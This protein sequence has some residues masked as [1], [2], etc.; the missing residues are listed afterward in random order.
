MPQ[1]GNS[2][3]DIAGNP[4]AATE[5]SG[6]VLLNDYCT[7]V[8]NAGNDVTICIGESV[9]IGAYNTGSGGSGYYNYR[10]R[11][12]ANGTT[13]ISTLSNPAVSPT[14]TTIYQVTVIDSDG[15]KNA[16]PVTVT[17]N[18]LPTVTFS[19][20]SIV[21]RNDAT[22]FRLDN[23]GQLSPAHTTGLGGVVSGNGITYN[24][25]LNRYYFDP[26]QADD[27]DNTITYTYKDGNGCEAAN[28][29]VLRVVSPSGA[30]LNLLSQYC[31]EFNGGI[32]NGLAADLP[33]AVSPGRTY[34]S[35]RL[36]KNGAGYIT[37]P[38][39]DSNADDI[40][41][42]DLAALGPGKFS[43]AVFST[44]DLDPAAGAHLDN[45]STSLVFSKG[46]EPVISSLASGYCSNESPVTLTGSVP[47]YT[48][49]AFSAP[50][51]VA[52]NQFDP[53]AVSFAVGQFQKTITITY[54]YDDDNGCPGFIT[55]DV[56]VYRVP[57]APATPALVEY[58]TEDVVNS[59]TVTGEGGAI[60][61]W[62]KDADTS[63]PA[64]FLDNGSTLD[65]VNG[66]GMPVDNSV[67]GTYQ[68]WV[69]QTLNGC[70]S[71]AAQ[72]TLEIY[73][74]SA[75][76]IMGLNPMYCEDAGPVT[77]SVGDANG[78]PAGTETL[79]INGVNQAAPEF[80]PSTLGIGKHLVT[81]IFTTTQGCADS[82]QMEV[83]VNP[84]QAVNF[85]GFNASR[86]YCYSSD[87][88]TLVGSPAVTTGT[89]GT[90]SSSTGGLV[91]NDGSGT[92][93]FSP[94]LAAIAAGADSLS[95]TTTHDI[96][97]TFTDANGC[98]NYQ[99]YTFTVNPLPAANYSGFNAGN[100]YCYDAGGVAL[101]G[102]P[103]TSSGVFSGNGIINNGDGTATFIP[104]I[105][106]TLAGST[107]P[108]GPVTTHNITYTFTDANSCK[109]KVTK[110]VTVNPLPAV[111]FSGYNVIKKY[112]YD[113]GAVLLTGSPKNSAGIFSGSGIANNGN[114]T[115]T[116]TP[117]LAAAD[118]G[119]VN[120]TDFTTDHKLI[121]TYTNAQG[122]VN[123]ASQIIRVNA[124]PA[125]TI[126]NL[127]EAYC[128]DQPAFTLK[129]HPAGGTLSGPGISGSTFNPAAAGAGV[130]TI[131]Y[132]YTNSY[133]ACDNT[134]TR[135]VTIRPLP[136]ADFSFVASCNNATVSFSDAS[137]I[138]KLDTLD[139]IEK[140]SWKFGDFTN[141]DNEQNPVHTYDKS[142][143]YTITLTPVTAFGCRSSKETTLSIDA[144][145]E[146]DFIWKNACLGDTTQFISTSTISL[147]NITSYKW[148]FGDGFVM[149][150]GVQEPHIYDQTGAYQASL[151]LTTKY[152]CTDSISKQIY[153]LPK[154]TTFPY[155]ED[156]E[157]TNHGWI[158]EGTNASWEQGK[159]AAVTI[160]V[161]A[162]G[163]QVFMTNLDE[164]YNPNE[165]SWVNSPC[166][167]ISALENPVLSFKTWY[168]TDIDF[169]GAVIQTSVDDGQTWQVLGSLEEGI[170]WYNSAAIVGRPGQQETTSLGMDGYQHGLA[171]CKIFV[172]PV[173][174][175]KLCTLPHSLWQQC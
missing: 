69:T 4:A 39:T 22:P 95:P 154:V 36:Y 45:F 79:K 90:F 35:L 6:A 140:Y 145:P 93:T 147:G 65:P 109:N 59:L 150:G 163:E 57:D 70:E 66:S 146:A 77:F 25:A 41:D 7:V 138:T 46:A 44:F 153:I 11:I 24:S 148:D 78:L 31:F 129:V 172:R 151:K 114:G 105:A 98:T 128:I 64:N 13:V 10:W 62:Y 96:T 166:F 71:P 67:A 124:L 56:T 108:T 133:T 14:A 111:S 170:A 103:K 30:V 102:S 134:I 72:V 159:P 173:C 73:Q 55:Q 19:P 122:C 174:R 16:D 83:E 3:F 117:A 40:Y 9:N 51:G 38:L 100:A 156:F 85:S 125:L 92:V 127:E 84:V 2:V 52:G 157:T 132:T 42:L 94:R 144:V 47:T 143:T 137:T 155:G 58:C 161:A 23:N 27:G 116:F 169:D 141:V 112:C 167:E 53:G 82:T 76:Q 88:V 74:R 20:D 119:A 15:C 34:E 121:Y 49:P 165:D 21:F 89:T 149:N 160:K 18:P 135:Q 50:E 123:K 33:G 68:Y 115:A 61:K 97:Y 54:N 8:A 168:L 139:T 131:S 48:N 28:S 142:G 1:D 126:A 80:D 171:K 26:A 37:G 12:P 86:T 175:S 43:V 120:A 158:V 118:S 87:P 29:K 113:D 91:N 136:K 107:S 110:T 5:T 17:V 164:V 101:T 106:A 63:I 104:N 130:H 32:V 75:P 81:F 162:S 152:G 99:T 60:F